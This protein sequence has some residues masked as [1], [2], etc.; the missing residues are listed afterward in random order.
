MH[1]ALEPIIRNFRK[2]NLPDFKVGQTIK[3]WQKIKEGEKE[4]LAG[5]EGMIIRHH[6]TGNLDE[7][8]TVRKIVDSIGVERIFPVHSPL[9]SKIDLLK[10]TRPRRARIYYIRH[11][12][13]KAAKLKTVSIQAKSYVPTPYSPYPPKEIEPLP[14]KS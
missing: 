6:R 3:I 5:F 10:E 9:I 13:G 11:T 8:I 12:S 2:E 7:S 1:P 14:N 4:R